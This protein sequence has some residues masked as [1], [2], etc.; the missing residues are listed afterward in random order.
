MIIYLIIFMFY[1]IFKIKNLL[2]GKSKMKINVSINAM[3]YNYV[4]KGHNGNK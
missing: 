3:I 1:E 4:T 2:K